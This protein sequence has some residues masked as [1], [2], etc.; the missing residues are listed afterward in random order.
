[1]KAFEDLNQ[2]GRNLMEKSLNNPT[3]PLNSALQQTSTF[4]TA[5][6]MQKTMSLHELQQIRTQVSTN[7]VKLTTP[8]N[9]EDH[10]TKTFTALN[11]LFVQLETIKPSSVEPFVLYEKNNVK[12]V[13]YFGRDQPL[14][15]IHVIVVSVTSSNTNSLLR[16]FALQAA[17]PKVKFYCR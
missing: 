10:A 9:G 1:M 11:S 12:V 15:D 8:G 13:L 16:N 4:P 2:L 5:S 14:A 3:A 6:E 7:D 17:V